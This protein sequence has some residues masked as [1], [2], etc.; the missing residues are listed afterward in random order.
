MVIFSLVRRI[1]PQW[2]HSWPLFCWCILS[3]FQTEG[4]KPLEKTGWVNLS[5]ALRL[6]EDSKFKAFNHVTMSKYKNV[7]AKVYVPN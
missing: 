1:I 7:F 2:R 3:D 6:K 4:V 5:R